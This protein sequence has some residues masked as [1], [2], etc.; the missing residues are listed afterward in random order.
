M[1]VLITVCFLYSSR[2]LNL[3]IFVFTKAKRNIYIIVI[4]TTSAV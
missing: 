4:C 2:Y 3:I 1:Y